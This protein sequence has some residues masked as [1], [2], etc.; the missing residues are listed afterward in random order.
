[1]TE[2]RI[3]DPDHVITPQQTDGG[4]W[5]VVCSCPAGYRSPTFT[6]KS[7]ALDSGAQ[8][9]RSTRTAERRRA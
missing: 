5:Y 6:S 7:Y 2:Y 9:I 3:T 4:R 1:M 8:H